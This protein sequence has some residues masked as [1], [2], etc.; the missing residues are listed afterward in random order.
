MIADKTIGASF[1]LHRG[2]NY[3]KTLTSGYKKTHEISW[4]A[5]YYKWLISLGTGAHFVRCALGY[6]RYQL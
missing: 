6:W 2:G 3:N 1:L 4:V 5:S